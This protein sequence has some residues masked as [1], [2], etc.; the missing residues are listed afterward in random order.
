MKYNE[1]IY[2]DRKIKT[3]IVVH[4]HG[5]LFIRGLT[6]IEDLGSVSMTQ[7]HVG[8]INNR[9]HSASTAI[10]DSRVEFAQRSFVNSHRS[11]TCPLVWLFGGFVFVFFEHSSKLLLC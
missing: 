4:A 5:S 9:G 1:T 11:G 2:G 6:L 10:F 8:V 7:Y 3:S